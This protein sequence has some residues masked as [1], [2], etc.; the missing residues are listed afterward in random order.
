MKNKRI[1]KS[2]KLT[3][4]VVGIVVVIGIVFIPSIIG[5]KRAAYRME[6]KGRMAWL[7]TNIQNDMDDRKSESPPFI[8]NWDE[9]KEF[10]SWRTIALQNEKIAQRFFLREPWN[11]K[12]NSPLVEQTRVTQYFTCP[13]DRDVET[14]ASYVA[15]SGPGTVW[16]ELRNGKIKKFGELSDKILF[17]ETPEPKNHWAKPGD[18]VSPE[19]V[20]RLY[21]ADPGL[22]KNSRKTAPSRYSHWPK[23]YVTLIGYIGS[24]DE[25]PDADALRKALVITPAAEP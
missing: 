3:L 20:I 5:A 2:F 14:R 10:W 8:G 11:S 1:L 7:I 15:V 22:V 16:T 6:C 21:K 9:T 24:F 4:A 12:R 18:D 19:E 25:F 23:H 13:G 17:I